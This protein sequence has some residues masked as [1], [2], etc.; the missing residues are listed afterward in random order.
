[1]E[2]MKMYREAGINPLGCLSGLLI[3]MPILIALYRVFYLSVGETPESVV[4]LS[5][6]IY[7]WDFLRSGLP[8]PADF[9][10]M[11]MGSPDAIAMPLA[12]AVSMY[13]MQKLTQVPTTDEKQ[14]AQQNMMNLMLPLMFGFFTIQWPSALGL[15]WALSNVISMVT[16]YFYVGGGPINWRALIGMSQEAVLPRAVAQRQE[17]RDRFKELG[18]SDDENDE[19][20]DDAGS[21]GPA[22]PK[23]P[24]PGS[25][26]SRSEGGGGRRRRRRYG[27]GRR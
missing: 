1:Q 3:Q 13:T 20:E 22:K 17:Q 15:Y 11:H 18:E 16:H 4:R 14:R 7:A 19:D 21:E 26:Q 27:R 9:L 8:L 6:K 23:S 25:D 5:E 10:W 2:M 12:V 24:R